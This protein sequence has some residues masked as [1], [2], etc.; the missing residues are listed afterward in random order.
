[1]LGLTL[2]GHVT[3]R[4]GLIL[5]D[6]RSWGDLGFYYNGSWVYLDWSLRVV[7]R[8]FL[9]SSEVNEIGFV[10]MVRVLV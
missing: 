6:E 9:H 8:E 7:A 5:F 1:M 3:S 2:L 10:D 4:F